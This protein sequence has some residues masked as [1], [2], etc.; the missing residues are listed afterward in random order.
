MRPLCGAQ[1]TLAQKKRRDTT[2]AAV[3]RD[4]REDAVA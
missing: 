2:T 1:A 3:T 4:G